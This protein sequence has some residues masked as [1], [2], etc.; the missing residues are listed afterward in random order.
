MAG[1]FSLYLIYLRTVQYIQIWHNITDCYRY[2]ITSSFYNAPHAYWRLESLVGFLPRGN[3][4]LTD[5]NGPFWVQKFGEVLGDFALEFTANICFSLRRVRSW[6][7]IRVVSGNLLVYSSHLVLSGIQ[8]KQ[9]YIYTFYIFLHDVLV[10][11]LRMIH[12]F[13]RILGNPQQFPSLYPFETSPRVATN[14]YSHRTALERWPG[15]PVFLMCALNN[16]QAKYFEKNMKILK[17]IIVLPYI[18]ID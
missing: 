14:D 6:R 1:Y 9:I 10:E 3:L 15:L 8:P 12:F 18:Q 11:S 5:F 7:M 13:L 17:D 4:H 2:C 16:C